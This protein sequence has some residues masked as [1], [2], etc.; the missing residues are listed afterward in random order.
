MPVIPTTPS[1]SEVLPSGNVSPY[2]TLQD[3]V[4][5]WCLRNQECRALWHSPSP[6][7]PSPSW[8]SARKAA[9]ARSR[10]LAVSSRSSEF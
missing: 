2:L 1:P 6:M 3:G 7:K 9:R 5:F 4:S 10:S 8:S